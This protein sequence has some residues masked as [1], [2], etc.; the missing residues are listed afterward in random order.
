MS[1]LAVYPSKSP[2]AINCTE[3]LFSLS[4]LWG[5]GCVSQ[6]RIPRW[7]NGEAIDGVEIENNGPGRSPLFLLDLA[8][9]ETSFLG[10][11]ENRSVPAPLQ[12]AFSHALPQELPAAVVHQLLASA[13]FA[14]RILASF[15]QGYEGEFVDDLA[16]AYA[17]VIFR[18]AQLL[19][20]AIE[21]LDNPPPVASQRATD[22]FM[23]LV[24]AMA[25][26]PTI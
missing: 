15:T 11:S 22:A 8:L 3:T 26:D 14:A 12:A 25:P 1:K 24:T 17:T 6:S 16:S 19:A 5:V 20:E 13:A 4:E 7:P 10:S 21:A 23:S 9:D 18:D 2:S